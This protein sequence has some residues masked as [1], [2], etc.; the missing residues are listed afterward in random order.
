MQFR[1]DFEFLVLFSGSAA[2]ASKV[3]KMTSE[4]KLGLNAMADVVKLPP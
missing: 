1:L 4:S 3:F 2:A